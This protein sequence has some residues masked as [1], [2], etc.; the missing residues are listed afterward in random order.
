[1]SKIS[2][3]L[4]QEELAKIKFSSNDVNKITNNFNQLYLKDY[5]SQD[6]FGE[7]V[8]ELCNIYNKEKS[9][10]KDSE[11]IIEILDQFLTEKKQNPNNIINWFLNDEINPT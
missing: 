11:S 2:N 5:K 3:N 8:K 6:F 4:T 9:K 7:I 1:M 10:G